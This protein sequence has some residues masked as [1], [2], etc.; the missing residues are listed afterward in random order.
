M[1]TKIKKV[2]VAI[3]E[4]CGYC[5]IRKTTFLGEK[6]VQAARELLNK[7]ELCLMTALLETSCV[8]LNMQ[9]GSYCFNV[10]L[11]EV[12]TRMSLSALRD[13]KTVAVAV[14]LTS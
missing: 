4:A 10:I 11:S 12:S 8:T 2:S 1:S 7:R 9:R 3:G 6:N 13:G 5:G 14:Y